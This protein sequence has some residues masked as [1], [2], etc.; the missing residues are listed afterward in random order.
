MLIIIFT[1]LPADYIVIDEYTQY[2]SNI[3][4][5]LIFF[6]DKEFTELSGLYECDIT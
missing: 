1:N 4:Y 5:V 6:N 3:F 2:P